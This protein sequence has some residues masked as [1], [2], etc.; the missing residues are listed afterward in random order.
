MGLGPKNLNIYIPGFDRSR[1]GTHQFLFEYLYYENL[2]SGEYSPWIA[3]SQPEYAS[4]FSSITV[5]LRDG[6]TWN[7]G[8]PFTADDVVFTYNMLL[9]HA[10]KLT[11]SSEVAKWMASVE[12]LDDLTVRFNLTEANPRVHMNREAF[13]AVGIWG[14][15]TIMPKHVW[16]GVD[17]VTFANYPAVTTGPYKLISSSETQFVYERR[18]DWWVTE[19]FGVV[20]APKYIVYKYFGPETSTAIALSANDLMRPRLG[21]FRWIPI[22]KS[23]RRILMSLPGMR[24]LHTPGSILVREGSWSRTSIHP[25]TGR[26]YGG[27]FLT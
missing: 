26:K 16:E 23:G 7:D 3:E 20:P 22:Y 19:K 10:P 14:G 18:D 2:E 15:I 21:S 13:P 11:W 25:L 12:K 27:R 1:S 17:P 24:E 9:E 8:Q 5:K 4:D 6:V